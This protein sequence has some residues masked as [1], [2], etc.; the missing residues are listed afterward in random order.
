[1]ISV[2]H[3]HCGETVM[4]GLIAE[5]EK[6]AKSQGCKLMKLKVLEAFKWNHPI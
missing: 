4:W 1:M 5:V 2:K 3:E 6:S